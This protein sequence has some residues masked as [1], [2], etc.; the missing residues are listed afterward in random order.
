MRSVIKNKK[1]PA[2]AKAKWDVLDPPVTFPLEA[3]H[4]E[5]ACQEKESPGN[6]QG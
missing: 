2:T 3:G 5:P 4:S 1:A 6:Y